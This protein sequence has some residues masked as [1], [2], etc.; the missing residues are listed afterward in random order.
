MRR[1]RL[2]NARNE[3]GVALFMVLAALSVLTFLVSE[4]V[5]VSQVNQKLAYDHFDQLKAHVLAKSGFKISLLRLKAYQQ[6]KSYVATLGAAAGAVPPSMLNQIWSFPLMFPLPTDVPGMSP[7]DKD[8]ILEFQKT[9]NLEGR[10]LSVIESESNKYNLN[11]LLEGDR[12]I[13]PEPSPS[14]SPST[15]GG[16]APAQPAPNP[17]PS[18]SIA[19]FDAAAARNNLQE[20]LQSLLTRKVETDDAFAKLYRDYRLSDLVQNIATYVDPKFDAPTYRRDHPIP[21]KKAVFFDLT[22]LHLI[23]GVEEPIYDLFAPVLTTNQTQGFNINVMG[24]GILRGLFP[25]MTNDEVADFFK[26]RDAP[27]PEDH[28]FK[29]VAAFWDWM[30]KNLSSARGDQREIQRIQDE[31]KAKNYNLIVDDSQYRVTVSASVNTARRTIQAIVNLS[32]SAPPGVGGAP[33][34]NPSPSP[35]PAGIPQTPGFGANPAQ[36]PKA[37]GIQIETLRIL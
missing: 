14:P 15:A 8:Q 5:Y 29:D 17:S 34:P 18:P 10:F 33:Q 23:P 11:S 16:G 9:S 37:T 31:L 30:T 26:Y 20:F 1:S 21:P 3:R 6:V 36:F 7:I 32:P 24:E 12:P 22:E 25:R 13:P 35:S 19:P 4:F 27:P 28:S 2:S